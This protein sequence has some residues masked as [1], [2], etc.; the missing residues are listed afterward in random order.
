[1]ASISKLPVATMRDEIKTSSADLQFIQVCFSKKKLMFFII[2]FKS[3]HT[4]YTID[5][6]YLFNILVEYFDVYYYSTLIEF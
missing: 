3:S 5:F 2:V 4:L 1:M 6:C